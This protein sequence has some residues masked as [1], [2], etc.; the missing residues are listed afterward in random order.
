MGNDFAFVILGCF[1]F[2]VPYSFILCKKNKTKQKSKLITDAIYFLFD[3]QM[4]RRRTGCACV[5]GKSEWAIE[6]RRNR[7]LSFS[8][9]LSVLDHRV[10]HLIVSG[11]NTWLFLLLL[12]LF[13]CLFF[14]P[15]TWTLPVCCL[16]AVLP[17]S[18][19][20]AFSWSPEGQLR[21]R[22]WSRRKHLYPQPVSVVSHWGSHVFIKRKH[23]I[24][25]SVLPF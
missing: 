19:V 15:N 5:R 6:T 23:L 20:W 11:K 10:P 7:L 24:S 22:Q 21:G 1:F 14:S 9:S 17:V 25:L 3:Q 18:R 2:F 13:F 4:S 8:L 16:A 12:L